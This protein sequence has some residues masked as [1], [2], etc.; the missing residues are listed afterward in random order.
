M[1]TSY[2]FGFFGENLSKL[3]TAKSEYDQEKFTHRKLALALDI[4]P[5]VISRITNSD[6]T[7]KVDNPRLQTLTKIVDY[8]I[9]AGF[10]ITLEKMLTKQDIIL[11]IRKSAEP[12]FHIKTN[13][14]LY[15]KDH[16]LITEDF[17]TEINSK[18]KA[19][20][21][22][23]IKHPYKLSGKTYQDALFLVDTKS[24]NHKDTL[25]LVKEHQQKNVFI[26][27]NKSTALEQ[28]FINVVDNRI[29]SCPASI[30][31]VVIQITL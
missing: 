7:A 15:D 5:S 4:P 2:N 22:I 23:A 25:C 8:F 13:I 1:P 28:R 29:I 26:A 24:K 19:E 9:S 21:I 18:I 27:Q 3:I 12:S 6:S 11:D 30:I 16:N 14:P 20:N 31:G 10:P 17:T